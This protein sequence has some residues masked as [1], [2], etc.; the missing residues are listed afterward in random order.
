MKRSLTMPSTAPA[1]QAAPVTEALVTQ[2]SPELR[3]R[4]VDGPEV[5]ARSAVAPSHLAV[6]D[7]VLVL[8]G[9]SERYVVGVLHTAPSGEVR[10][11]SGAS[12]RVDG[13]AVTVR[14]AEGRTVLRYDAATGALTLEAEA[15]DVRVAAP[16][17]RVVLE[18]R[19]AVT[20]RAERLE[21]N[22]REAVWTAGRW[23]LRAV[24]IAERAEQVVRD[25]EGLLTTR[26]ERARTIVRG[27]YDLVAGRT[28][29][30]S[31]EDTVVDGK[32]VLL[33]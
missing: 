7:R 23:E 27:A 11:A 29:I 5:G 10:T 22:V 24:R 12:A 30:A 33:G 8:R 21:G 26:A 13:D 1:Y 16:N 4:L 15:G 9:E 18:A 6:G 14:D 20:L 31:R 3:V 28:K 32:R 19:D 17:G 25:V 2:A